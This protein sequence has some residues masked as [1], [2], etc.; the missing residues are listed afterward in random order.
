MGETSW[1]RTFLRWAAV[2]VTLAG[3]WSI[4]SPQYSV[5]DEPAHVLRAASVAGGELVGDARTTRIEGPPLTVQVEH[6][7]E[8]PAGLAGAA[9]QP[10]CFFAF[11][12]TA[13]CIVP[14][15]DAPGEVEVPTTAGA[16]QPLFYGLVGVP[17]Q[18][19]DPVPGLVGARLLHAVAGGLLLAAACATAQAV[20]GAVLLA[21]L[22]LAITP[23]SVYLLGGVNPNGLEIAAA[24][25]TWVALL[26]LLTTPTRRDAV[27]LGVAAVALSWTRPLSP[28]TVLGILAVGL[29][30]TV[31]RAR[32]ASWRAPTVWGGVAAALLGVGSAL[33]W[34]VTQGA[35]DAFVGTPDPDLTG[36]VALRT[37]LSLTRGRLT[38]LVGNLGWLDT[39]L[40]TALVLLWAAAAAVVVVAAL[41]RGTWRQ[42]LVVLS[43]CGATI[44]MPVAAET[45]RAAEL[46]LFWQGRYS[47]PVAVGVIVVSGWVLAADRPAPV[48]G[49]AL[50]ALPAVAAVGHLTAHMVSRA[51]Y[52][53]GP[54]TSPV[55]YLWRDGWSAP[56]PDVVLV[57]VVALAVTAMVWL[58][59]AARSPARG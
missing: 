49:P 19:L 33:A 11:R 54:G 13:D 31:T 52:S 53:T 37:S 8:V 42:R 48:V 14:L 44:L 45:L 27:L 35:L 41:V 30:L 26:A 3:V 46:G 23:V 59:H 32:L 17:L 55:A 47:L 40:P 25:A 38:E 16:Y 29:A 36:R 56:L 9:V 39:P 5:P 51:R 28:L 18:V 50:L 15:E 2:W 21:V 4:A 43:L 24:V 7:V 10:V 57:T 12:D 58:V 1:T 6:V 20:G 34:I 22:T